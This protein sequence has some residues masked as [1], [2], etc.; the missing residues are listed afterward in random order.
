MSYIING[1]KV[2]DNMAKSEDVLIPLR[3][4]VP[5]WMLECFAPLI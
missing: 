1:N 5:N 3:L 2:T 4:T